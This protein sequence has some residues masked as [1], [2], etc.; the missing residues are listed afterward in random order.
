MI[1]DAPSYTQIPALRSLW[2]QA[3]GDTDSFL[4]TFF[5]T[6]FSP[7]RCRCITRNGQLAAALYWFDCALETQQLAYLYAVATEKSLRGQG[8]CR[9][10]I[11]QTH[12]HL[13]QLGYSGT[14]LVPG[15]AELFRLYAKLGYMPFGGIREFSCVAGG[16]PAGLQPVTAAQYAALRQSYLPAD[17]VVQEGILLDF[18]AAQARFYAGN[19]F[20]LCAMDH[21][22][23]LFVPELLGNTAAAAG[24]LTALNKQAGHFRTP[25]DT[26]F[27]MYHSLTNVCKA[28]AYFA[29][30]LD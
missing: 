19:D 5:A 21:T 29:F 2:Q 25:G 23:P 30:A 27:A 15:S 9:A 4:D 14:V 1:I 7:A 18:L 22:D 28:P 17:S 10:L 11:E 16:P 26:P 24:I 3:F 6:A 8:L 20:L 12:M 13:R